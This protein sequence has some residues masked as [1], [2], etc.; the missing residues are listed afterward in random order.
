MQSY[1][2][3]DDGQASSSAAR[4]DPAVDPIEGAKAHLLDMFPDLTPLA[5][6]SLIHS[7]I[8]DPAT[9]MPRALPALVE[10][11]TAMHLDTVTAS[12]PPAPA[13]AS[14]F[15]SNSTPMGMGFAPGASSPSRAASKRS[16]AATDGNFFGGLVESP[17]KRSRPNP[18]HTTATHVR[19]L[20]LASS[21]ST[22]APA[23]DDDAEYAQA[24]ATG[25]LLDC[26]TCN[27]MR[28]A[29]H[30][31]TCE[32]AHLS[33]RT[34]VQT[35]LNEL[36]ILGY[37]NM[38]CLQSDCNFIIP[39]SEMERVCSPE[40]IRAWDAMDKAKPGQEVPTMDV[41]IGSMIGRPR[42]LLA[43]RP[44]PVRQPQAEMFECPNSQLATSSSS[45]QPAPAPAR[46]PTSALPAA[47]PLLASA[48]SAAAGK[49]EPLAASVPAA[50]S[51]VDTSSPTP[52]PAPRAFS[53][54]TN[55]DAAGFEFGRLFDAGRGPAEGAGRPSTELAADASGSSGTNGSGGQATGGSEDQDDEDQDRMDVDP[56]SD[57]EQAG[58]QS[59]GEDQGGDQDDDEQD[60]EDDQE[61]EQDDDEEDEEEEQEED[62]EEEDETAK[63]LPDPLRVF[64]SSLSKLSRSVDAEY[65]RM[66]QLA[67]L[68]DVRAEN[69]KAQEAEAADRAARKE[70][71]ESLEF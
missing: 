64:Y 13:S 31:L 15:A 63:S 28:P 30:M 52:I 4:T 69:A 11:A 48:S 1:N 41:L 17:P 62:E 20:N 42:P 25:D 29:K 24:L 34:C 21:S 58:G 6:A 36:M 37:S 65:A 68:P 33:C 56:P 57:R 35:K 61:G 10:A 12:D 40:L 19:T 23:I 43:P 49:H 9:D 18:T 26:P 16:A 59:R 8:I 51:S 46:Q 67:K 5:A 55:A 27:K 39:R 3:D 50:F 54:K 7:C 22:R 53:E 32:D 47:R 14:T 44:T 66:Q 60:D 38:P 45:S 2:R 71:D 70:R